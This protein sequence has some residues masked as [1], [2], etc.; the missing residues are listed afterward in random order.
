MGEVVRVTG[1][2]AGAQGSMITQLD[3]LPAL[4]VVGASYIAALFCSIHV[5]SIQHRWSL[6]GTILRAVRMPGYRR[7]GGCSARW[8]TPTGCC[9][10]T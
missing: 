6:P 4:S 5:L 7:C 2:Q 3:G 8:T 1:A 9:R 10:C